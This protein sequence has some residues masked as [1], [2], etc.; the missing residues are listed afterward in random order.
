M[1]KC[2]TFIGKKVVRIFTDIQS[3]DCTFQWIPLDVMQVRYLKD[4]KI[5]QF[6]QN[7]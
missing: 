3:A 6:P 2:Q 1:M 5:V 7:C 4:T